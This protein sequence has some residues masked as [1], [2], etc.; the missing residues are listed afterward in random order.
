MEVVGVR[1][2]GAS[3]LGPQ[4]PKPIS[5]FQH[6]EAEAPDV[7]NVLITM[8]AMHHR[9]AFSVA[10][11]LYEVRFLLALTGYNGVAV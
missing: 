8:D 4:L 5:S 7:R 2:F 11:K 10:E 6:D 1:H 3:A 9:F